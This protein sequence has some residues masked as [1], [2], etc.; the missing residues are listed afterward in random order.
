M[1]DEE[2]VSLGL[3][4]RVWVRQDARV[5]LAYDPAGGD[6]VELQAR[7]FRAL[8]GQASWAEGVP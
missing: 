3:A 7:A 6:Y 2:L 5:S 4:M 1:N 8:P